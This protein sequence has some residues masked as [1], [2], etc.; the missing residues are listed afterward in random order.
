MQKLNFH[1]RRNEQE[2]STRLVPGESWLAL[3]LREVCNLRLRVWAPHSL[4]YLP[5][6]IGGK[7]FSSDDPYDTRTRLLAGSS[8]LE[9]GS[10]RLTE[11]QRIALESEDIGAGILRSLRGQRE[12]I[13]GARGEVSYIP[14]CTL[15]EGS[16]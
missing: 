1:E 5:N 12:V 11:T 8:T 14:L 10:R 4:T 3:V 7:T 16:T 15:R 2:R 9:D 13:E 6:L